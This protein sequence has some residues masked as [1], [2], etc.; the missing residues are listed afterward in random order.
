MFSSVARCKRSCYVLVCVVVLP[1]AMWAGESNVRREEGEG[2]NDYAVDIYLNV[3]WCCQVQKELEKAMS[4]ERKMR[5]EMAKMK[6]QE[7]DK[8]R[9]VR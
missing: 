9:Q 1:G 4:E 3:F 8:K 7:E 6:K 5:E 2:R